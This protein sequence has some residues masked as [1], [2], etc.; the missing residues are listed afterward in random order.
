VFYKAK[1]VFGG[2]SNMAGGFPLV[3]NGIHILTS[4]ALYQACYF[5]PPPGARGR[6]AAR[7]VS[8]CRGA[9]LLALWG[10]DWHD[11]GMTLARA[12][13]MVWTFV[14]S[15]NISFCSRRYYA[16]YRY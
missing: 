16:L 1:E 14:V 2:L 8:T 15:V 9:K 6:E 12:Q 5:P 3:V 10:G 11:Q 13:K 7:S 4:E